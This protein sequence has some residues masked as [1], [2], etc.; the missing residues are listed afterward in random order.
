MSRAM[1]SIASRL[2]AVPLSAAALLIAAAAAAT[3]AGAW[4]FELVLGLEPCPLC[5]DQRVPYYVAVPL[6]LAIAWLAR[7]SSG[8]PTA[9]LGLALLGV[10]LLIGA[11]YGVYHAGIEWGFWQGPAACAGGGPAR[12]SDILTS[13]KGTRRVVSCS[14]AA[15]R[16]LGI[17][18][19]GYNVLIAAALSLLALA[20]AAGRLGR[21]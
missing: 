11:G 17:S 3:L 15:W 4:F 2:S 20:A 9:R 21:T 10:V 14:E 7:G 12:T 16:F 5:L 8:A 13:L 19:A 1:P 18:L 6:G